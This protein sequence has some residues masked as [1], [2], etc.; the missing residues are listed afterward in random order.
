VWGALGSLPDLLECAERLAKNA[1][2]LEAALDTLAAFTR[3]AAM[4]K[5]GAA[6]AP[7][8]SGKRRAA[9]D[10]IIGEASLAAILRI[11]VAQRDAQQAL[12]WHAQP[13]FAAERMLLSMRGAMGESEGMP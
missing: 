2:G 7:L 13:R 11:H 3:D 1:A 10:R 8:L 9:V 12:G 5:L 4:T 6:C